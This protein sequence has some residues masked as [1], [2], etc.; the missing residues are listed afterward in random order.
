MTLSPETLLLGLNGIILCLAYFLIYPRMVADDINKLIQS[1][2][3]ASATSVIVAGFLF[4]GNKPAFRPFI[5]RGKLVRIL[6]GNVLADGSAICAL[7]LQKVRSKDVRL[8][9]DFAT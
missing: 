3:L 7:V 4:L 6:S 2:L 8:N 5:W 9:K 1:D